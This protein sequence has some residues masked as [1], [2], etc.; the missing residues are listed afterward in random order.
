MT[1]RGVD[2]PGGTDPRKH[3]SEN[4]KRE[5]IGWLGWPYNNSFSLDRTH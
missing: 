5:T 4:V 1:T 3:G 2:L